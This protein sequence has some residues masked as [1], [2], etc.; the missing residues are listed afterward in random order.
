MKILFGRSQE[1]YL[2]ESDYITDTEI[3]LTVCLVSSEKQAYGNRSVPP[4][5]SHT[6]SLYESQ[7]HSLFAGDKSSCNTYM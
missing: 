3:L 1:L 2:I 5:T 7:I 4:E 6:Q